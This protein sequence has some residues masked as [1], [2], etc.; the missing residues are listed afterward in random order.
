MNPYVR[1]MSSRNNYI[2]YYLAIRFCVSCNLY[3][4]STCIDGPKCN[5]C[6]D[7][8]YCDNT[9]LKCLPCSYP[10]LTCNTTAN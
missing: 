9:S 1:N 6:V 10:C 7:G 3:K 8:F 5:Q 2:D 4:A